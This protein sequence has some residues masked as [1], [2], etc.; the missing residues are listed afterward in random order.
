M[1]SLGNLLK[2]KCLE[3]EYQS[4]ITELKAIKTEPDNLFNEKIQFDKQNV[5]VQLALKAQKVLEE[6]LELSRAEK[7][8][9]F[10]EN[11][12]ECFN[13]LIGK[14]NMVGNSNI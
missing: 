13:L 5:Q 7:I 4:A 11:I 9:D 3:N 1:K 6:Y 2:S 8:N 12:L 10:K 14:H